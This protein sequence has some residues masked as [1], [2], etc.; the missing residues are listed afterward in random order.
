MNV[1]ILASRLGLKFE[2]LIA[3]AGPMRFDYVPDMNNVASLVNVYSEYDAVQTPA[4]TFG[5]KRGEGRTFGDATTMINQ[6]A[7]YW[8][9]VNTSPSVGHSDLHEQAVWQGNDLERYLDRK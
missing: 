7:P 9:K 2:K 6:H 8:T 3:L 5:Y 1:C 4:G